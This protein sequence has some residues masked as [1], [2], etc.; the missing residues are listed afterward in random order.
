MQQRAQPAGQQGGRVQVQGI[1]AKV[2]RHLPDCDAVDDTADRCRSDAAEDDD[3]HADRPD[4]RVR[5]DAGWCAHLLAGRQRLAPR[6][7][8]PHELL[9]WSAEY[10]DD[11]S[12]GRATR[13]TSRRRQDRR[14]QRYVTFGQ[15]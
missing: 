10:Q 13:K 2:G 8:V 6:P 4:L 11:T 7:A 14:R 12:R 1:R 3:D 15:T 5:V 9:D